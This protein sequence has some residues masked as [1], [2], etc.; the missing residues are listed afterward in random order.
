MMGDESLGPTAQLKGRG[1]GIIPRA[2]S[3]IFSRI[4]ARKR[5]AAARPA[6]PAAVDSAQW[7]V[8]DRARPASDRP[9]D[10][11]TE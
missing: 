1:R 4:N 6:K 2:L 5:Q 10:R 3:D 11:P 7:K 8:R 9:S